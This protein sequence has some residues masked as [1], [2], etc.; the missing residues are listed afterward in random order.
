MAGMRMVGSE[1]KKHVSYVMQDDALYGTLT[2]RENLYYSA[3]LRLPDSMSK[4]GTFF[5]FPF[6]F[7][8][9]PFLSSN[10]FFPEEKLQRVEEVIE[11][12]GLTKC[13]DT[14]VGTPLIRGVSGGERRRCSIGNLYFILS[15][16]LFSLN[17]SISPKVFLTFFC[18]GME[19]IT[20]PSIL[21]LDEPTSG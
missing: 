14:K 17:Q 11:M 21:L 12:L 4:K 16:F 10:F 6:P 3:M 1:M 5:F 7:L 9:F 13:A 8:S 2:V 15:L 18:K 20:R 19:L